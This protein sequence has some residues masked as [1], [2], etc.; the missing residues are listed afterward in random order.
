MFHEMQFF[1][2]FDVFEIQK[3]YEVLGHEQFTAA[4][5]VAVLRKMKPE[6]LPELL[7]QFTALQLVAV[8]PKMELELEPE[9]VQFTAVQFVAVLLKM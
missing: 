2:V 5:F 4:Q 8:P 6:L 3:M 1:T 7:V 9:L